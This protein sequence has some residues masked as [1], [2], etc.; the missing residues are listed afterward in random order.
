LNEIQYSLLFET[1]EEE[2]NDLCIQSI[3]VAFVTSQE[4]V[5]QVFS[6]KHIVK[7]MTATYP[8]ALI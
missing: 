4:I 2:S 6:D 1:F 8:P 5:K 3:D 7:Y